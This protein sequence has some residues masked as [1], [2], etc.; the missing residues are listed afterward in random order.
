[1]P[2]DSKRLDGWQ[3]SLTI[4]A[5][6]LA[7][8]GCVYVTL[9]ANSAVPQGQLQVSTSE[10]RSL[11][12]CARALA[13]GI[14]DGSVARGAVPLDA[15]GPWN[16]ALIL[17]PTPVVELP[18][19]A[20]AQLQAEA[21]SALYFQRGCRGSVFPLHTPNAQFADSELMGP[22]AMQAMHG[23]RTLLFLAFTQLVL[24]QVS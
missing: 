9:Y 5:A 22:P 16:L 6:V 10:R 15:C 20:W 3:R 8:I 14:Q 11:A 7:G 18:L 23:F 1:M 24:T 17:A 13:C 2:T 21:T 19:V 12:T 4:L